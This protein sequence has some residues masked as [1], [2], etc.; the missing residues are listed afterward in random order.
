MQS[1]RATVDGFLSLAKSAIP[2][3]AQPISEP[4]HVVSLGAGVQSTT[5]VLMAA[6]GEITPMPKAA[7]FADT[8]WEPA[9]VYD[10]LRWL[11]SP[12][13]LPFP[14]YIVSDGNIREG[15]LSGAQGKRW[16]SLPVFIRKATGSASYRVGMARRQCTKEYKI[17]PLRRASRRLAGI[18]GRRWKGPPL[19]VQWIGISVDEVERAK[20]AR[21]ADATWQTNRHPLLE[22]GMRRSDCLNWLHAKDYPLPPKSACIGCPYCDNA[23]WKSLTAVEF[24]DAIE[25]D[26]AIRGGGFKTKGLQ[27]EMYLHRTGPL[28]LADLSSKEDRGQLSLFAEECEGICG[29]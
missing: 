2:E 13:V 21:E 20:P 4:I 8:G 10:H 14:V 23:A 15:L 29:V 1:P 18:S 28:R 9:A 24:S 27:G 5:M 12:N 3:S 11:M 22:L 16:A 6:H 25:V 17:V 26:E 7:V 19:V